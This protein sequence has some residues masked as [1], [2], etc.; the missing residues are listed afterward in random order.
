MLWLTVDPRV[1]LG[2][3]PELLS[4]QD[5]RPVKQQLID[6][7]R[8][9]GGWKPISGFTLQRKTMTLRYP[10]DPPLRPRARTQVRDEMVCLYD[11]D[12]LLVLQA[13][14]SFEVSRVD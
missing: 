11:Y 5:P 1:D 2:F 3:L 9:G 4:D 10:G 6:K 8:Y 7:Y 13:D 14:G 12:F